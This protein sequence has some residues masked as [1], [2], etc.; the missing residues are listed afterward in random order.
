MPVYFIQPTGGG[1]I[2]IGCAKSLDNLIARFRGLQLLCPVPLTLLGIIEE[3]PGGDMHS[4]EHWTHLDF[5]HLAH[6]GEW[7]EPG[8][9]LL[10]FI[11]ANARPLEIR[12]GIIP[13]RCAGKTRYGHR[14]DRL[15]YERIYC[16]QHISQQK[17]HSKS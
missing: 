9:D 7:F 3:S 12:G 16:K 17:T 13:N 8:Q 2:K 4:I 15:I 5:R 1:L 6:H 14:C 11:K 10:A